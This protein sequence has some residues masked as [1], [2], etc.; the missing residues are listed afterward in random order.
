MNRAPAPPTDQVVSH[1]TELQSI[2]QELAQLRWRLRPDGESGEAAEHAAAEAR[3]SVLNLVAVARTAEAERQ[4]AQTLDRLSVQCPSRTL[5]LL[6]QPERAAP[7]L[8]ATITARMSL[9]GASRVTTEQVQLHA[10][11]T[12][13]AHLAS[14][15]GPL[16]IPDLPVVLWWPGRPEFGTRLLDEL[17]D[18]CDRMIV[19]TEELDPRR[20]FRMLLDIA[21]RDSCRCAIGDFSWA[22]I[23]P[24]R[25]LIAQLFDPPALRPALRSVKGITARFGAA[26]SDVQARL[27][28]GWVRS[29]LA[30][31]GVSAVV[32]R[33]SDAAEPPGLSQLTLSVEG[34]RTGQFRIQR[35]A[36]GHLVT[37]IRLGD[38]DYPGHTVGTLSREAADLLGQQ[39]TVT[40]QD[41]IY[42]EALAAAGD[43]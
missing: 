29:R 34:N 35:A 30:T 13:A 42:E 40:G 21:R 31:L 16:L 3:A 36:G 1:V 27:L 25:D 6:A 15:V 18:L 8:E 9:L 5:V 4:I 39:L 32:D 41:P 37:T 43:A 38:Q 23:L 22:R 10:H 17:A 24:W 26:G 19:D 28:A 7:K 14:I 20:D 2:E 12:T 33:R 11:G